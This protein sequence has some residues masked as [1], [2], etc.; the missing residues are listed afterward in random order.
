MLIASLKKNEVQVWRGAYTTTA[1]I[2]LIGV[3]FMEVSEVYLSEWGLLDR[4]EAH[5]IEVN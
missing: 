2:T 1:A 5:V 4:S 3:R